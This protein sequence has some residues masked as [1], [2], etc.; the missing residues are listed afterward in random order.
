MTS[1]LPAPEAADVAIRI[2]I[3]DDHLVVR[4]GLRALLDV[5]GI[6]VIGEAS[7]GRSAIDVV[8]AVRPDVVLMDIRMADGGGLDAT[9]RIRASTPETRVLLITSFEDDDYLRTAIAA[10]ADG[11]LLK[12][13]SR[14]L[15]VDS[16][17][18]VHAG[19]TTFPRAMM[20]RLLPI[21]TVEPPPVGPV[22]VTEQVIVVG[23][24]RIDVAGHLV[25][26]RETPLLLT[27]LEF[28][29]LV[30]LADAAGEVVTYARL[31]AELWPDDAESSDEPHRVVSLIARVRARLGEAGRPYLRTV[32]R[33]GYQLSAP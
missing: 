11:F 19:G 12:Q 14:S 23:D 27:Y 5:P 24:L 32:K 25:F 13:A 15:L 4:A 28:R 33:V 30:V 3:V 10:G 18:T 16:I 26:L 2:V 7:S 17:R 21:G 22:E 29:A 31:Q 20:S 8:E 6:E 1:T 9:R